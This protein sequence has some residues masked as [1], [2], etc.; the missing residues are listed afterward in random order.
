[1][2]KL[3]VFLMATHAEQHLEQAVNSVLQQSLQDVQLICAGGPSNAALLQRLNANQP[4]MQVLHSTQNGD[5]LQAYVDGLALVDSEYLLFLNGNDLLPQHACESICTALQQTRVDVLQFGVDVLA[6]E[7]ASPMQ[8]QN[9]R[10]SL[11]PYTRPLPKG[12]GNLLYPCLVQH[13]FSSELYGKLLRTQIV[14]QALHLYNKECLGGAADQFL[15]FMVLVYAQSYGVLEQP[16]YIHR[17]NTQQRTLSTREMLTYAQGAQ[18][19]PLLQN[20]LA[21]LSLRQKHAQTLQAVQAKLATEAADT[22]LTKVSEE[23]RP[24]TLALLLQYWS[25]SALAAALSFCVYHQQIPMDVAIPRCTTLP[26]VEGHH[27]PRT[28]GTFY[29]RLCNGGVER[30]LSLLI[31]LWQQQGLRVVLFTNDPPSALDYPL[32]AGV[33]RVVLPTLTENSYANLETRARAWQQAIQAH[34]VDIMV[35]HAFLSSDLVADELSIRAAG[36][37]LVLHTHGNFASGL[38]NASPLEFYQTVT[39]RNSYRL[40][41]LVV[42]LSQVD[43]AWWQAMDYPCVQT[44]NPCIYRPQDVS[45]APLQDRQILWVGRLCTEKQLPDALAILQLVHQECPDAILRV[46]GTAENEDDTQ[47]LRTYLQ[48]Q[49]LDG[50]I[51]LEGFQQDL[52]PYYQQASVLLWTS[53]YEGAPVAMLE[54]MVFGLPVVAYDLPNVDLVRQRQGVF[55]VPQHN[56]VAAAAKLIQ[57]LKDTTFRRDAGQAAR[58]AAQAALQLCTGEHWQDIFEQAFQPVIPARPLSQRPPLE[59]C[60]QLV[61]DFLAAGQDPNKADYNLLKRQNAAY[62]QMVQEIKASCSYRLGQCLTAL[63]RHFR[64][65]CKRLI[66]R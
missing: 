64:Q 51:H 20:W 40:C 29:Y 11:Q 50:Y 34:G 42:C 47:R 6:E 27:P 43:T 21:R 53:A 48:T 59:T 32:P 36:I 28:V 63:P 33:E 24:K 18:V 65:I 3:S 37:P 46:V 39:Q 16:C 44:Q 61:M 56:T 38:R 8:L 23:A 30:V 58:Q 60:A 26:V 54:G 35:Y 2:A 17:V 25:P 41:N 5:D 15:L 7:G 45:P 13:L 52:A 57:L 1:M 49:G 9:V 10:Q 55:A 4:Y 22:F 62:A 31:P 19:Y 14:R 66:H 12:E